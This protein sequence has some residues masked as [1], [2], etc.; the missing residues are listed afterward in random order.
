V[1]TPQVYPRSPIES[2]GYSD[3]RRVSEGHTVDLPA[4]Q[5]IARARAK[6]VKEIVDSND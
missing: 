2:R 6:G 5:A 1:T 3:A 4:I